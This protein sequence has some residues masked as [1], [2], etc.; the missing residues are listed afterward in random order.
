MCFKNRP[1]KELR[2]SRKLLWLQWWSGMSRGRVDVVSS[3]G[4]GGSMLHWVENDCKY[5]WGS[6][7]DT[8]GG[9]RL[10]WILR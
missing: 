7:G 2:A 5:R 3:G 4:R 6:W 9:K 1:G 8:I 10:F